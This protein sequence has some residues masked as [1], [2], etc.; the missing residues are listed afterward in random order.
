VP[1]PKPA[2]ESAGVAV[3]ARLCDSMRSF[4]SPAMKPM[5]PES[6][7]RGKR[8]AF[9]TPMR[10]VAAASSRSAAR[11]SGRRLSRGKGW[12]LE[13]RVAPHKTHRGWP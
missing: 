13:A 1:L 9:A 10:A 6:V 12:F 2:H 8:S 4:A 7:S 3:H 11:M 5:K